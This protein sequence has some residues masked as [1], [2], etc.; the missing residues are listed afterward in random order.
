MEGHVCI[1]KGGL[2]IDGRIINEVRPHNKD[3]IAR[4]II[5]GRSMQMKLKLNVR[6]SKSWV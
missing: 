4:D 1:L 2:E 5:S 3:S 6:R